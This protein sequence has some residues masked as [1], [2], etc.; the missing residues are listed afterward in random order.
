MQETQFHGSEHTIRIFTLHRAGNLHSL[1]NLIRLFFDTREMI[2]ARSCK[3][4]GCQH[5][6]EGDTRSVGHSL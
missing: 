2:F 5:D 3:S 4:D 1:D 6:A